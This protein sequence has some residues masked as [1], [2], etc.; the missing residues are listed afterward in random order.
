[1]VAT[2]L[3]LAALCLGC[4]LLMA[5]S[6]RRQIIY[7]AEGGEAGAPAAANIAAPLR[8]RELYELFPGPKV[9]EAQRVAGEVSVADAGVVASSEAFRSWAM[10]RVRSVLLA[11]WVC[12][13]SAA[14]AAVGYGYPS[15]AFVATP[16]AELFGTLGAASFLYAVIMP[17]SEVAAPLLPFALLQTAREVVFETFVLL[18]NTL[19]LAL[20]GAVLLGESDQGLR[21]VGAIELTASTAAFW[22]G[23]PAVTQLIVVSVLASDLAEKRA[24]EKEEKEKKKRKK[25]TAAAAAANARRLE[26][27]ASSAGVTSAAAATTSEWHPLSGTRW[28]APH[29]WAEVEF[30]LPSAYFEAGASPPPSSSLTRSA[31]AAATPSTCDRAPR[32]PSSRVPASSPSMGASTAARRTTTSTRGRASSCQRGTRAA[33]SP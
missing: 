12:A 11:L 25:A 19:W 22:L 9:K 20:R 10:P 13:L 32:S 26:S 21:V 3:A 8:R 24:K 28:K 23:A 29:D 2:L 5:A 1:M 27:A 17:M 7:A 15:L 14:A 6:W 4:A 33:Q 16:V 31:A 30:P 18:L